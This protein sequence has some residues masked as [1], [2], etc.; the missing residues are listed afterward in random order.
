MFGALT[1]IVL[2]P[3]LLG[4]RSKQIPRPKLAVVPV[5]Q[6]RE[7][8]RAR[9]IPAST[10]KPCAVSMKPRSCEIASA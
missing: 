8:S 6:V 1:L 3:M 4:L 5:E 10:L 7:H 2:I 9:Q